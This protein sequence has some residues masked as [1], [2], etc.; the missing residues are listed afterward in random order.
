MEVRGWVGNLVEDPV[1]DATTNGTPTMR[2]RFATNRSYTD[3]NGNKV[4][5]SAYF[6]LRL[7][8]DLA[9]N[10][11]K[12]GLRKGSRVM[13]N[14]QISQRQ[15][16]TEDG[17]K[18]TA[19]EIEVTEIGPSLRWATVSGLEKTSNGNGNGNY[20]N[21]RSNNSGGRASAPAAEPADTANG[22]DPFSEF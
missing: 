7:W 11:E 1:K 2:V 4:D 6:T 5:Q 19:E 10:V 20:A 21:N 15:Y 16:E 17:Q 14:G 13:I 9:E 3:R 8:R 18:R 22:G 12:S